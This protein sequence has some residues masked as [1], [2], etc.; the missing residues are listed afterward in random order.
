MKK[1]LLGLTILASMGTPALADPEIKKWK[2]SHAMGC[3]MVQ[4]CTD[5]V[6][7]ITKW[8]DLGPQFEPFSDELGLLISELNKM[9]V[10]VFLA[11]DKYF[12]SLTRGLYYVKGNN[13]FLNKK[14]LNNALMMT[15]VVRHEAWHATQDCMAGTIDNTL[16][17]VILQDGV[18]PDWVKRGADRT[19]PEGAAPY[20]AEAMWA[21]FNPGLVI[22][23]VQ[24]CAGDVPMWEIFEPTP[25]TKEWLIE[26]G[27]YK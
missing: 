12:W 22:Q 8:E 5:G 27:Y 6:E 19:Y 21:A 9:G 23:G 15:K 20:E 14:Y 1:F 13:M 10:K 17:A 2:T 24:A 4:E 7:E 18:V 3:M 16:T 11:D 26:E 25:M